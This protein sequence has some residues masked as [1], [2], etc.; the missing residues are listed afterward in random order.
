[1]PG[2]AVL[3][4][5]AVKLLLPFARAQRLHVMVQVVVNG[6]PVCAA[7]SKRIGMPNRLSTIV[8]MWDRV[9]LILPQLNQESAA[10]VRLDV[11]GSGRHGVERLATHC[12][13]LGE[14]LLAGR[15]T[16]KQ[17]A[18]Y[19]LD[20]PLT[21]S[22]NGALAVRLWSRLDAKGPDAPWSAGALARSS[23]GNFAHELRMSGREGFH[24][25]ALA[26]GR[27]W[28]WG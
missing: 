8:H 20:L 25:V 22:A 16:W 6:T 5:D 10:V 1:M 19:V 27:A 12:I 23:C 28:A 13:P 3:H 17:G 24:S 21:T 18:S 11:H 14:M 7:V 2:R 26:Q 15:A 4:L 9:E